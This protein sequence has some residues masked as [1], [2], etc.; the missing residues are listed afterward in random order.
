ML[1]TLCDATLESGRKGLII[2]PLNNNPQSI[3][4]SNVNK[5]DFLA[6]EYPLKLIILQF[7]LI[8]FVCVY[9]LYA[10]FRA[11]V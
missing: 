10:M 6:A 2:M 11:F 3:V 5:D 9:V 1:S 4:G 7:V 8:A